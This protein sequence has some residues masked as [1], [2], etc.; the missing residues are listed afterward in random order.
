MTVGSESGTLSA[1]RA[2]ISACS[3]AAWPIVLLFADG[4]VFLADLRPILCCCFRLL[5]ELDANDVMEREPADWRLE[6]KL[7]CDSLRLSWPLVWYLWRKA[8]PEV[9]FYLASSAN[10]MIFLAMLVMLGHMREVILEKNRM[11]TF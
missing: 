1:I 2:S 6:R 11:S 3:L 7:L 5:K 8:A 4:A 9:D 10:L